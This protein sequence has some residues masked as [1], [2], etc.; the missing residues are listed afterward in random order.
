MAWPVGTTLK[1]CIR[2]C[3]AENAKVFGGMESG[4]KAAYK[5][6]DQIMLKVVRPLLLLL[7]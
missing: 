7:L 1:T 5:Y 6:S 2:I 4:E 3:F